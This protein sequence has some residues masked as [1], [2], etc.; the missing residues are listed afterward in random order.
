MANELSAELLAQMFGQV[1][2]D[3]FIM[4]VTLTHDDFSTIR[5]ANNT[6]NVVSRGN[7][8]TAF[9]MQI[10]LPADTGDVDRE[11]R[12]EFDNV[13]LSL[14]DEMRSISTPMEVK[15]EMLL[16]SDL[17]TVQLSIEDL[18]LRSITYDKQRISARLYMDSFLQVEMTSE[19]Y[20]PNN[21]PGLF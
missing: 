2:D 17:E 5:L 14:I 4:L 13:S 21:F 11:V 6:V 1:S 8:Y 18:K 10:T 19:I 3:P 20:G 15:I 7:T 12:I 16:A 9:P